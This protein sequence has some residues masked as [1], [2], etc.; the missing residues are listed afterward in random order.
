VQHFED[1]PV[2]LAVVKRSIPDGTTV[3]VGDSIAS[4]GTT[5]QI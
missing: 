2:A 3:H 4:L 5:W 1:G